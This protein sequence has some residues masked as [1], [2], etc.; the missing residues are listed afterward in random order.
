MRRFLLHH[1]ALLPSMYANLQN[2]TKSAQVQAPK[3]YHSAILLVAVVQA[4]RY[5]LFSASQDSSGKSH[6]WKSVEGCTG[7]TIYRTLER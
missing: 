3:S 4:E 6:I 2:Y 1:A 5:H 7:E